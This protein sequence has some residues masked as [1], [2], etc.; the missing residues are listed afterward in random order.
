VPFVR[1]AAAADAPFFAVVWFH[2]PHLPLLAGPEHLALYPDDEGKR[3]HYLGAVTAMD[4]QIGRLRAELRALGL[5][6]DTMLFFCSDNGPEGKAGDPG[7]T[8]GL[9]GRKRSLYEGGI[10]VPAVWEWPGNVPAG[11]TT[12]FAAVTSDYLP[13]VLDVLGIAPAPDVPLDGV[14]LR[15]LLDGQ[16]L[17]RP[18]GIGF[19]SGKQVAWIEQRWKLYARKQGAEGFELYDLVA[20]PGERTNLAAEHSDVV[21]RMATALR[22]WRASCQADRDALEVS[23][24]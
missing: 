11:T 8:G 17:A 15:P 23:P 13:T 4:Q 24:R 3:R 5:E 9:R 14:S 20:D 6:R 22:A 7:T 21:A 12:N 2:T 1:E 18:A 19:E 10:R 16:D